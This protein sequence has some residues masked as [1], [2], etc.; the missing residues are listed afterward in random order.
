M[1]KNLANE[2]PTTNRQKTYIFTNKFQCFLTS[3]IWPWE[4]NLLYC[5]Y[6]LYKIWCELIWWYILLLPLEKY[7]FSQNFWN[8]QEKKRKF[9]F[10]EC[11]ASFFCRKKKNEKFYCAVEWTY[12]HFLAIFSTKNLQHIFGIIRFFFLCF[13][14]DSNHISKNK[15]KKNRK[16]LQKVW[17]FF[18]LLISLLTIKLNRVHTTKKNNV[19]AR[20][21]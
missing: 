9:N 5:Y 12:G 4:L 13:L 1:N 6:P 2:E 21:I 8:L 10:R 18:S 14:T 20:Q 19:A 3:A 7:S 17:Y 15:N 16:K 11:F